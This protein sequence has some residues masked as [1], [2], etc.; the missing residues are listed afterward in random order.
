MRRY[1]STKAADAVAALKASLKPRA[2]VK[3]DGKFQTI[4]AAVL[5]PGDLVLLGAGSAV[6][7]DCLVSKECFYLFYPKEPQYFMFIRAHT[8]KTLNREVEKS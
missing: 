6:P 5:V 4:D 1:E 2:T 7:A 8:S 3:R